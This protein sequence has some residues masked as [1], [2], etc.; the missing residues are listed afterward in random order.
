MIGVIDKPLLKIQQA[1]VPV[2]LKVVKST[3]LI[4]LLR[5]DWHTKYA[6]VTNIDKQ[7]LNFTFQ[8]Q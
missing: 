3:K 5:M 4:L 1:V 6:V 7:T 8:G 2:T